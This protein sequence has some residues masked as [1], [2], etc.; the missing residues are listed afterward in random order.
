[1]TPGL[2][3]R[4][5]GLILALAGAFWAGWAGNGWRLN[6][7]NDRERLELAK[8]AARQL[9]A[10]TADR[11][12]KAAELATSNDK[13]LAELQG[14]QNETNR[15]RDCL[16]T[17]SCGLRVAATCPDYPSVPQATAAPGVDSGTRAEL[18]P[19]AESAYFALRDGIDRTE[20][21]LAAC[22]DELRV[23]AAPAV[24]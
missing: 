8:Q 1:M 13:H 14:A 16:R 18:T 9:D 20:A 21:K 11:D 24:P 10:M 17:G 23:R 3:L 6:A 19:D 22:Q 4:L 12:A 15:L 7:E 5:G 2:Y